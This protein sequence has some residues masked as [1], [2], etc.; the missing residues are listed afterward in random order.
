MAKTIIC[1][2]LGKCHQGEVLVGGG[3]RG[4]GREA[5]RIQPEVQPVAQA[6]D[7]A[8]PV[9]H[10]NLAAMEQRFKNLIM[11][12][13]EPRQPAPPA[14]TQ[15]PVVPQSMSDQLSAEAKHLRD[16]RKY[17]PT[18]FDGLR[19][20]KRQEF[21]NLDQGDRT[22]EQYDADFDMLS[23]FAPEMIATEAARADKFV[24]GLRLDIQGL[25]R[26]FQL[27]THADALRLTMDFSLLERAN[28]FKIAGRG[29]TSR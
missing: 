15:A 19:D 14:P 13:Q 10:A 25:V 9:T 5:G 23:R 12:M 21:L 29:S 18:T 16:F 1:H 6:T 7:P 2:S 24:G 8:A 20:A 4:R 17:N 11:Q 3:R 28:S 26:A 22:V 27:A